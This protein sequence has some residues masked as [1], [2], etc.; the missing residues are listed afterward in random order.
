MLKKFFAL[1]LSACLLAGCISHY[2]PSGLSGGYSDMALNKDT[3]FVTF[4]GNGFT[5]AETVQSYTLRRSA[6]I[7]LNKGYKYFIIVNGGTTVNSQVVQT[8]TT[9]QTQSS[10]IFQGNGYGHTSYY[11]SSSSSN[12]NFSGYGNSNSY[13]TINPGSQYEINRFKSGVTIKMLHSNSGYSHA[14]DASVIMS[15]YQK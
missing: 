1:F 15:N 2:Q 13:T 7:T 14:Y 11:G 3:Y 12:Y 5:S 4:R 6:E 10:G 9:I 8:P